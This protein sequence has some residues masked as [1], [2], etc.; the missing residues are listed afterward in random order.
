MPPPSAW[1]PVRPCV[2]LLAA[3]EPYRPLNI[4]PTPLNIELSCRQ[5]WSTCLG[6]LR[7]LST[8]GSRS[9]RPPHFAACLPARL[10]A[11]FSQYSHRRNPLHTF[12][13]NP[14]FD[15]PSNHPV[16][17]SATIMPRPDD[18]LFP[19]PFPKPIDDSVLNNQTVV[20][21]AFRVA[22]IDVFRSDS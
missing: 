17:I 15:P 19:I 11:C 22:V 3:S 1:T 4:E 7:T 14:S 13:Q 18:P 6:T 21:T 9:Q 20:R 12:Y 8:T 5:G 10:L 2:C 16:T